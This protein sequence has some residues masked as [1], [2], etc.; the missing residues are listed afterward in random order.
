MLNYK[1][2]ASL[3]ALV[4]FISSCE[5]RIPDELGSTNARYGY[6]SSDKHFS[7][8]NVVWFDRAAQTVQG[9]DV[10]SDI[11]KAEISGI[12]YIRF[13]VPIVVSME[14]DIASV[15]IQGGTVDAKKIVVGGEEWYVATSTF[16]DGVNSSG[17]TYSERRSES[18][19]SIRR[20]LMAYSNSYKYDGTLS[21]T[22]YFHCLGKPIDF[23]DL[24]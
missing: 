20:G 7:D 2:K 12:E 4:F 14:Q 17:I 16:D 5:D 10:I 11:Y 8:K 6:C 24:D 15:Q 22:N 23:L 21:S 18:Y 19:Y 1:Y 9:S 3:I 13:P